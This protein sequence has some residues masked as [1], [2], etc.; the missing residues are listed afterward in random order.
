MAERAMSGGGRTAGLDQQPAAG[1]D[2]AGAILGHGPNRSD[3]VLAYL[4]LLPSAV[5]LTILVLY[6]FSQVIFLGFYEKDTLLPDMTWVGLDN[7]LAFF[8]YPDLANAFR[9]TVYWTVGSVLLEMFVGMV[10]ALVLHQSL[11][12][13]TIARGVVLF[14]YLLPTIVA[15]LVW[16]FM[17]SSQVGIISSTVRQLG[18]TDA[19]LSILARP[20]TAML[21]VILVGTWKFFPFVVIAL[22]GILQSIPSDRFE[23]ARCD[24]ASWWQEFRYITI[25]A[26]LPVIMLT[27]LLRTIWTW[28]KFDIIYQLTGG[29]PLQTTTTMSIYVYYEMFEQFNQ[30]RAAAVAMVM[31]LIMLTMS[32]IYT[33]L[34]DRAERAQS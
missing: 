25:P 1:R 23:A 31:F 18:F 34:Y 17:L 13:R 12:F 20:E 3:R 11:K 29:G 6:P 16:K 5:L 33:A 15:V 22:L 30:G 32:L 14:P 28:D 21:G 2:W 9:N 24:G 26:I 7:Y 27:A 10:T 4:F 19:P 8:Q